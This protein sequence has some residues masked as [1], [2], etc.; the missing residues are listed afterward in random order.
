MVNNAASGEV[1][2]SG[3]C[4]ILYALPISRDYFYAGYLFQ[5]CCIVYIEIYNIISKQLSREMLALVFLHNF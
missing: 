3:V 1:G 2:V 5:I 4:L